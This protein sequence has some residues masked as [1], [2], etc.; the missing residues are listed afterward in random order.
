[1]DMDNNLDVYKWCVRY[2][3]VLCETHYAYSVTLPSFL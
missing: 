1:M 2:I 3:K